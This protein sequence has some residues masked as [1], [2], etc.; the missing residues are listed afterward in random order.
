M[1][2][3]KHEMPHLHTKNKSREHQTEFT[4]ECKH[5]RKNGENNNARIYFLHP[6]PL[7][8]TQRRLLRIIASRFCLATKIKTGSFATKLRTTAFVLYSF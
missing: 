3:N 7:R 8:G 5:G 1:A 4:Y 2:I 6:A